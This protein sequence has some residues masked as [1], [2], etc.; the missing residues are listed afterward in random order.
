MLTIA[1][2][3]TEPRSRGKHSNID[4]IKKKC[5]AGGGPRLQLGVAVGEVAG[6][7]GAYSSLNT[8]CFQMMHIAEQQIVLFYKVCTQRI[9]ATRV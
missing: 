5:R 7:T 6:G 8:L 9:H 2:S 1:P 3:S 4:F